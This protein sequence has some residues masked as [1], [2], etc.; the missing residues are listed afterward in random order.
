MVYYFSIIIS[1]AYHQSSSP[2]N[3]HGGKLPISHHLGNNNK[4]SYINYVITFGVPE[5]PPPRYI[6]VILKCPQKWLS[7]NLKYIKEKFDFFW[8]ISDMVHFW[9][10]VI[11]CPDPPLW[12]TVLIW[13]PPPSPRL[14]NVCTNPD[15]NADRNIISQYLVLFI[16]Q[17]Q[18]VGHKTHLA[19][20]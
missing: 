5:T 4:D 14:R 7:T 15:K 3:H 11:L 12:Y 20:N 17:L 13:R 8:L 16:L 9:L 1:L 2:I 10:Y 19:L 6:V 18:P